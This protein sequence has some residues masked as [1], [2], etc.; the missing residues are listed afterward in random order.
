MEE[1]HESEETAV[2]AQQRCGR[3]GAD[4]L[5]IRNTTIAVTGPV[6]LAQGANTEKH[7]TTTQSK[8]FCNTKTLTA[9]E[10]AHHKQ[11]SEKLMAARKATVETDRGYEFQFGPQDATL[12]DLADWV[13]AESKC[14]PFFD[15][16]ID[17]ENEGKL[18]CLRVTG[19]EG[20]KQ[21]MQAEF[22]IH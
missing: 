14:C 2:Y 5:M 9:K 12:A 4:V 11:L 13:V 17:L 1:S 16:H 8:L 6:A 3:S 7:M 20:V 21:F 18:I 19:E 22:G 15:F 10:W